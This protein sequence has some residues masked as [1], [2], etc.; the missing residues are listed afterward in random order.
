MA[1]VSDTNEYEQE[2]GVTIVADSPY[3]YKEY[4][5]VTAFDADATNTLTTTLADH[6]ITSLIS[7][8]GWKHTTAGVIVLEQPTTSV[9]T[10]VLT[11]TI[12]AGTDN[13]KR[14]YLIG[15]Y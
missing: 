5:V 13:D 6:G 8:K 2:T 7:V 11:I 9:T 12:P 4:I 3:A 14:V 15:G 10:G 1:A